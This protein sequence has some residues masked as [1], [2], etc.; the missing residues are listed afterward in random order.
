MLN[1]ININLINQI[2]IRHIIA[3]KANFFSVIL[4]TSFDVLF[5]INRFS[6]NHVI[7]K[8]MFLSLINFVQI[9]YL[10]RD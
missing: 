2:Q 10:R 7:N 8:N 6:T 1:F 4:L 5:I 3:N 9:D